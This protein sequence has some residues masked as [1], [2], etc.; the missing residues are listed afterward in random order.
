MSERLGGRPGLAELLVPPG[1]GEGVGRGEEG[2]GAGQPGGGADPG[3]GPRHLGTTAIN[4]VVTNSSA[5]PVLQFE[6]GHGGVDLLVAGG[7]V[8]EA[9]VKLLHRRHDVALAETLARGDA[10]D[11]GT[12]RHQAQGPCPLPTHLV[13]CCSAAWMACLYSSM[14]CSNCPTSRVKYCRGALLSY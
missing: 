5:Y 9:L 13:R 4:T 8:G 6:P 10:A 7:E 1:P 2:T 3:S 12:V 14:L 11:S